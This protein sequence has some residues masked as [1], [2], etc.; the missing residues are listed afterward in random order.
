MCYGCWEEKGKP[1]IYNEQIKEAALAVSKVFELS[2]VGGNLHIVI[3][4]WNLEDSALETCERFI[5]EDFESYQGEI[6][7]EK[8][9]LKLLNIMSESERASVLAL[10]EGFHD[11]DLKDRED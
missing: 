7:V 4:D 8:H 3:D 1:S 10:Y 6:E 11:K 9:C 5:R 2:K